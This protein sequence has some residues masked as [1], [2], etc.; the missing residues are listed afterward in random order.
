MQ[1]LTPLLVED[2]AVGQERM[3]QHEVPAL[4]DVDDVEIRPSRGENVRA[5]G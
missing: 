4:P 3:E 2:G 1:A 5:T